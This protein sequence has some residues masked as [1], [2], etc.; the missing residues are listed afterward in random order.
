MPEQSLAR[1]HEMQSVTFKVFTPSAL[2]FMLATLFIYACS[3]PN[4]PTSTN[5][6]F[7]LAVCCAFF[8]ILAIPVMIWILR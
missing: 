8:G 2:L 6:L 5:R 1:G 3:L 4:S 7:K